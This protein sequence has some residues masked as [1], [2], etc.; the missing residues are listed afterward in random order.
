MNT[1]P[2]TNW[3]G[4]E[5]YFTFGPDSAGLYIT[6][7]LAVLVFV[8]FIVRMIMHENH[9]FTRACEEHRHIDVERAHEALEYSYSPNGES[10]VVMAEQGEQP[11]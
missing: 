8:G 5:A 7:A 3:D 10:N 6:L 4:A 2:I 1:S 11:Q 9:N